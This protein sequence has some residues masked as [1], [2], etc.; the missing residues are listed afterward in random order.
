M[1]LDRRDFLTGSTLLAAASLTGI[2]RA[3]PDDPV[4]FPPIDAPSEKPKGPPPQPRAPSSRKGYA[5]VG[6]GRIALEQVLPAFGESKD[7]KLVALVSGHAD[8]A[9]KIAAQHGVSPKAIYDYKNFDSIKDNPEIDAV[10]IALPNAMHAELTVRAAQAGKH[11]LC[12]KPMATSAADAQKMVDAC[13]KANK[14]L[15]IAYRMQYEPMTSYAKKLVRDKALGMIKVIEG[16]NGQHLGSTLD[17]FRLKKGGGAMIDVGIYCLNTA[18]FL[19]GEEP[20]WVQAAMYSTPNDKRWREVEETVVWSMGFPSGTIGNFSTTFGAHQGRRWRAYGDKG[21]WVGMDPAFSYNGLELRINQVRGKEEIL[22]KPE[23]EQKQ[24]FALELDHFAQC[25]AS[26][27]QPY[28][29]GEEGVQDMKII[30]AIF[31]SARDGKRVELPK[32][33]KLDAFRGSAPA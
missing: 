26:D 16:H 13:A 12:E 9:N 10:Y 21:G 11:V 33:T 23:I 15:M 6:L 25:M 7:A 8:K 28:T 2:A 14:K 20:H 32:I 27:K 4:T 3:A 24:H 30:E 22:E 5:V 29:K 1:P 18:R 19:L 17:Q 31:Q